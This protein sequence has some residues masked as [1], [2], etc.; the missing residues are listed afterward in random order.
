MSGVAGVG[1]KADLGPEALERAVV[2]TLDHL[3]KVVPGDRGALLQVLGHI[4]AAALE[5]KTPRE[6]VAYFAKITQML[7]GKY[8]R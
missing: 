3:M 7:D 4:T 8:D 1:K 5:G 6:V 2:S